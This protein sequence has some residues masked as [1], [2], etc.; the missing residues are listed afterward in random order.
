MGY[1]YKITN[2][3]SGKCYIGETAKDDPEI[4]WNQH[5]ATIRR[6]VGCPALRDA[7]NKY[8]IENFSIEVIDTADSIEEL[9]ELEVYWIEKLNAR[10][11]NVGYNLMT[12]GKS[13][14]KPDST[15]EKL[16]QKKKENCKRAKHVFL[17]LLKSKISQS[18]RVHEGTLPCFYFIF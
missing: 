12:G 4:R 5:K 11:K 8:G 1:I 7:V 16:R 6:G 18:L 9:N 15:K 13:G 14:L 17:R 2:T 10:D 3:V